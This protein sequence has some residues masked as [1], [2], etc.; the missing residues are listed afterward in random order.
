MFEITGDD[1]ALLNDE[2]LRTLI[3]RLC[4]SEV[5]RH[6][7]SKSWVTFG[8]NQNAG[9]GGLDVRVALPPGC[10]ISGFIRRASTG[11]QVKCQDLPPSAILKEMQPHG[12][13]RASISELA[14]VSGAYVIVSSQGSTFRYRAQGSAQGYDGR[15]RRSS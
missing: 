11:F 2:D 6:G 10:T 5:S 4:E 1:I 7:F 14:A 13:L 3:G 9:D 12:V 15:S 8:G